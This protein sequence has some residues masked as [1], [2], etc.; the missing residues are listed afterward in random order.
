MFSRRFGLAAVAL[1]GAAGVA[2]ANG[3]PPAT[4]SAHSREGSDREL[5]VS[6]TFGLLISRDD[7]CSFQWVCE[8]AIGY[9]GTFDPKYEIARDGTIYATTSE[10]GLRI[11]RDGGCEFTTAG[12]RQHPE[13]ET[14]VD[15]LDLGPDD[16]VWIGTAK[17]GR[18]NDVYHSIDAGRTFTPVG[19][20]SST[21]WWKSIRVAPSL[22]TRVYVSGY[23]VASNHPE[24]GEILPDRPPGPATFLMR[25]DDAGA[26]WTQLALD[27]LTFATV[28]VV[29]VEAVDPTN[30]D[31][32]LLRSVGSAFPGDRLY[33]TDSG[34][35]T[36]DEVLV[37]GDP[38]RDVLF[39]RDGRVL[40]ATIGSGVHASTDGGRNFTPLPAQPQ[41]ACL[42]ERSDGTLFACGANWEPDFKAVARSADASAWT[43]VFR[44]VELAAP[45]QCPHH[46]V[47]YEKCE[48]E[49]WPVLREQFGAVP[50]ACAGLVPDAAGPPPPGD[51]CCDA[52]GGAPITALTGIALLLVVRRRRWV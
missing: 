42:T 4:V 40:A 12:L 49:A 19:L 22:G 23:Q 41:T 28:P 7:G 18:A 35:A 14:W 24:I 29:L 25:S 5:Y 13:L 31:V 48:L 17:S 50:P 44:F 3:R 21:I 26:H 46:T 9:T 38:I 1:A 33:R 16:D 51:G 32:V 34:G 8:T 52:S 43:K 10:N 39:T 27:G 6:T 36:W 20:K 2:A 45:L 30:P 47:Q 11:S 15:A 37:T